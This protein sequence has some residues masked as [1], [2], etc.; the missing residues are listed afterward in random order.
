MPFT[1]TTTVPN[2]N[3]TVTIRFSGLMLLKPGAGN[4][5][6]VG[7]HHFSPFHNFQAM[8]I[9]HKPNLPLTFIRL[10]TGPL[11]GPMSFDLLPAPAPGFCGFEPGPFDRNSDLTD[12]KD[13]RW[14]L[15]MR[16]QHP[17]VDFS[18]GARPVAILKS[19]ILYTGNL[20]RP[21]LNLRLEPATEEGPPIV[22]LGKGVA[23]DLAVAIDNITSEAN[24]GGLFVTWEEFGEV[25][26]PLILPR[27]SDLLNHPGTT[28][29]IALMNDPPTINPHAHDELDLYYKVLRVGG[30]KIP[31]EEQYRVKDD[32]GQTDEVPC[33]PI[34]V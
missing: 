29:T 31:L 15:N 32:Q 4:T 6:E 12:K 7:I 2:I 3:A 27:E 17:N 22:P 33:M 19:G 8:L 14:V 18:D 24:G 28:Y 1:P 21:G 26:K 9:V 23:A 34:G 30:N 11:T 25:K 5:C 16:E 10:T 20:T 13:H